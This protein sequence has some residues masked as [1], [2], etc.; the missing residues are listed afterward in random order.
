MP[1][2][3]MSQEEM[4]GFFPFHCLTS[5]LKLKK[6]DILKIKFLK[7]TLIFFVKKMMSDFIISCQTVCDLTYALLFEQNFDNK[8]RNK[9]F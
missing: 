8:L 5:V 6:F 9:N 1:D 7:N 4:A 2:S 3:N